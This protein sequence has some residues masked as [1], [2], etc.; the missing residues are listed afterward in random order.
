VRR[1]IHSAASKYQERKKLI[2]VDAF[3]KEVVEAP[4]TQEY[5]DGYQGLS[6]ELAKAPKDMAVQAC[7]AYLEGDQ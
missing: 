2:V 5:K 3:E 7:T 6:D 1:R 4:K